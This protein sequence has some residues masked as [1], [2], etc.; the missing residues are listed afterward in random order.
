MI[1]WAPVTQAIIALIA[2]L[3]STL[4]PKAIMLFF[5]MQ[6][7]KIEK[8]KELYEHYQAVAT[9]AV[10]VVQQTMN[11]FANSAKYIAAL[12]SVDAQLHLP[13]NT[14]RRLIEDAVIQA[15]LAWG[16]AWAAA[17]GKIE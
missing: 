2:V 4:I 12:A 15:K 7:A 16:P 6:A 9:E 3:I 8:A 11:A 14:S 17:G 10:N 5:E 13:P 1:D